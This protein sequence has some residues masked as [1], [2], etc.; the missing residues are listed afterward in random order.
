MSVKQF[1]YDSI[2]KL[3]YDGTDYPYYFTAAMVS[4]C[5]PLF[6]GCYDNY[7]VENLLV[8]NG[9][10][11]KA[12]QTDSES[13]QMFVNFKRKDTAKKF[14]D[15]LNKYLVKRANQLEELM[16]SDRMNLTGTDW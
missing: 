5:D 6:N 4:T 10:I 2:N 14:I 3:D 11:T 15:R 9:V 7:D 16:V 13:C 8:K 1:S 12:C